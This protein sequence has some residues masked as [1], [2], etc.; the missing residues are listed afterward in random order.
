MKR[1]LLSIAR[2]GSLRFKAFLV[3]LIV[4]ALL[5]PAP[6]RAVDDFSCLNFKIINK[7][8]LWSLSEGPLVTK[9]VVTW[10]I[11]DPGNCITKG[12]SGFTKSAIGWSSA[13]FIN[14]RFD[15]V[16]SSARSGTNYVI[17][18]AFDIPNT[19]LAAVGNA[20]GVYSDRRMDIA[21]R[22]ERYAAGLWELELID[23]KVSNNQITSEIIE[24]W[25]STGALWNLLLSNRQKLQRDDCSPKKESNR[26][27]PQ[28]ATSKV[29]VLT[30]GE[31]PKISFEITDPGNC[32]SLVHTPP[33]G[34]ASTD[35]LINFPFWEKE[36]T[37]YW[38]NLTNDNP[39]II[40]AS[41]SA[42]GK[43]V[44]P[45]YYLDP[46]FLF[47]KDA[48]PMSTKDTISLVD[49]KVTVVSELD[50]R[51]IDR[52]TLSPTSEVQIVAGVYSVFDAVSSCISGRWYV[53]WTT[54]SSFTVRYSQGGCT[55]S[56]IV[57]SYQVVS[58]KV[59]AL[60][61]LEVN[62][63]SKAASELK[64]KQDADVKAAA[65]LK[66]KQEAD[67]KAAAELKAKQEADAKA[68]A[69]LKA[70]QEADAKAAAEL[71][72][73]QEADAKAAA[74]LKAKQEAELKAKQEL[75]ARIAADLKAKQEAETKA[76]A[77]RKTT[78]TCVKGKLSKKIT[79]V[80]PKCPTGYKLKK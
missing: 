64:A 40:R 27:G 54:L 41:L 69:E 78:I 28:D 19:W 60:D 20:P 75:E 2:V 68:A 7:D 66:A 53:N 6:A 49:N 52:K 73:K 5:I 34:K 43:P 71:K 48:I 31:K 62:G 13:G 15:G 39:S 10:S 63:A 44:I 14:G 3:Y 47:E 36:G 11:V 16:W 55:P 9:A 26:T 65:E 67:A 76:A 51:G 12:P 45:K 70:K 32:V 74:E 42:F 21:P 56:G 77:T 79:A 57:V 4:S 50:F 58:S 35:K 8:G 61:L 18:L 72:A 33:I 29:K 1:I 22:F 24:A 59:L 23:R 37:Q 17:I 25:I 46:Y 38:S 30:V 80:K